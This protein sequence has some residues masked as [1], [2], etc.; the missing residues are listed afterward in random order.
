MI[1][2]DPKPFGQVKEYIKDYKRVLVVGCGTCVTV[3]LSGGEAEVQLLA[4]GLRIALGKNGKN[5]VILEGT[6]QRQCDEEFV[7]PVLDRVRDERID[8]VVT[9]ACGVGVNFLADRLGSVP[10][11]PGVDTTF[12]GASAG[13]GLWAELCAGCGNCITAYTGGICPIARCSKHLLNGPC[14]GSEKG[15]CEVAPNSIDCVWQLIYDRLKKL[16]RL[17][18][19]QNLLPAKDWRTASD[20]GVRRSVREYLQE[21]K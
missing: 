8:A 9:L 4:S 5:P 10:V 21:P 7:V 16:G 12:Y 1:I 14:G 11:F 13:Q 19:L 15:R 20:G 17:S 2:A 6:V 3:C 18:E